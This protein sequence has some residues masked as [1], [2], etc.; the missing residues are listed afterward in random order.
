M[1]LLD[2]DALAGLLLISRRERLVEVGI[3]FARRVVRHVEQRNIGGEGRACPQQ[4][5]QERQNTTNHLQSPFGPMK[6]LIKSTEQIT[7]DRAA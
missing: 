4:S 7:R 5:R 1:R 6:H 2:L 3:E